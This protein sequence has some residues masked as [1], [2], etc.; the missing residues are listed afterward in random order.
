V[1]RELTAS[2]LGLGMV[3]EY[4]DSTRGR[5]DIDS[6]LLLFGYSTA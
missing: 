4:P 3:R 1:R 2:P 5:G 6:G